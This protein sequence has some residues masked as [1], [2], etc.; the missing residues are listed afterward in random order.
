MQIFQPMLLLKRAAPFDDPDW[1]FELKFSAPLGA[2][3]EKCGANADCPLLELIR[4]DI[5]ISSADNLVE[6]VDAN[7]TKVC[8]LAVLL[9]M[10]VWR[11]GADN[12]E[13]PQNAIEL[14]TR[15]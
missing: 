1:I 15:R 11:I 7:D 12:A 14:L 10:A 6:V 8:S 4:F 5:N 9:I 3:R 13:H 2:K